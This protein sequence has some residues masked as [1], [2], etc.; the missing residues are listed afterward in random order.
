MNYIYFLFLCRGRILGLSGCFVG[1]GQQ[2]AAT[3]GQHLYQRFDTH[4]NMHIKAELS[5]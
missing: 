2:S 1:A 5:Q 3:V 4:G